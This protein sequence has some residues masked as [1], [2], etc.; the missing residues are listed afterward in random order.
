M[1]YADIHIHLLPGVDDGAETTEDMRNIID[2]AYRTGTRII[3]CTPHYHLGYFGDNREKTDEVYKRAVDYVSERYPDL[4]LFLGN[5]LR[6][7]ADCLE[8]LSEGKCKSLNDT[9]YVLIDF[10]EDEEER[11]ITRALN[12]LINAGWAPV[13]AHVERYRSL[14]GRLDIIQ[15]YM[16]NG[17]VIQMDSQSVL[18]QFGFGMKRQ[19]VRLLK[20]QMVDVIAS[21]AHNCDTRP[22]ELQECFLYLSRKLGT[23]YAKSLFYK[24]ACHILNN[25]RIERV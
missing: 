8:W 5:E 24:N 11:I 4:K 18:G 10:T 16:T 12:Q 19:S 14:Y 3:C 7:S 22:P 21:D 9:S 15:N 1:K 2:R 20:R 23:A 6:Y 25:E 17:V 13:L